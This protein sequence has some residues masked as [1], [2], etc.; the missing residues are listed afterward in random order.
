MTATHSPSRITAAAD[1]IRNLDTALSS[2][3]LSASNAATDAARAR[4]N[5]RAAGEVARRYG[6]GSLLLLD[7][8]REKRAQARLAAEA[9]QRSISLENGG[10]GVVVGVVRSPPRMKWNGARAMMVVRD[11]TDTAS[12]G[13][14]G[15][16]GGHA[17]AVV[18]DENQIVQPQQPQ[19]QYQR[20]FQGYNTPMESNHTTDT[21]GHNTQPPKHN[22]LAPATS[23]EAN[24]TI[25]TTETMNTEDGTVSTLDTYSGFEDALENEQL[26]NG[27]VV[28]NDEQQN[29][30]QQG[31]GGVVNDGQ[32]Q[33]GN[34]GQETSMSTGQMQQ[35]GIGY[36][37]GQNQYYDQHQGQQQTEND[38]QYFYQQTQDQYYSDQRQQQQQYENQTTD[39]PN[40]NQSY[41]PTTN[42]STT[43]TPNTNQQQQRPT[44]STIE[45]SHAED[46][47]SLSLELERTRSQLTTTTS[48]LTSAQDHISTLQSHNTHLQNE[49]SRLHSELEITHERSTHAVN[50]SQSKYE[51]EVIRANAGEEDAALALELAKEAQAAKEECEEWLGRSLEEIELWRGR[52]GELERELL[53]Y[54][55]QQ[56]GQG[57]EGHVATMDG[58]E[59][60][61]LVRFADVSPP[62]PV[63]SEDGGYY[64]QSPSRQQAPATTAPPPPPPP[65][66][67]WSTPLTTDGTSI[68]NSG[69]GFSP[70]ST[71][72]GTPSKTAIASGRAILH[73]ASPNLHYSPGHQTGI[74]PHPRA[75][76]SELLK[77][78]AETRRLLRERL[79]TPSKQ[80]SSALVAAVRGTSSADGKT[81]ASSALNDDSFASRQ[82]AACRAVGKTIRE[83]GHRLHLE[84]QWW[85]AK[86]GLL[87]DGSSSA[88]SEPVIEG[89]AQLESM[90]KD[91]C[92]SV[93][94]KIG[95][96][97]EK[98][99][100]LEAFCD[101]LEKEVVSA[102]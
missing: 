20:Q 10:G 2:I 53:G 50:I 16:V 36:Y 90:V 100:E 63:V 42:E 64:D 6:G 24:E 54:R 30:R 73:R 93:E 75:Q 39:H 60:K 18:W 31:G 21:E 46:V 17:T 51:A 45:A 89:V 59:A 65:P 94:G 4:R 37:E 72:S 7:K 76:A 85:S 87:T 66:P 83:S 29:G 81:S 22:T 86:N 70:S 97:Q 67:A 43:Q 35:E 8:K 14:G 82:G 19:Q 49:L 1:L 34:D 23:T 57:Q 101:H 55:Q 69:I 58:S 88:S 9:R 26:N 12:G 92:G 48:H 44:S 98:I 25:Q 95:K 74:S 5:A 79:N 80:P 99:E 32:Y 78:S 38:G 27:G 3:Q 56:E 33:G 11:E 41:Q 96:Q 91:Y 102:R 68:I 84:G 77:K 47:L 52:C 62:S 61:K 40:W 15:G 71:A 13:G 28:E